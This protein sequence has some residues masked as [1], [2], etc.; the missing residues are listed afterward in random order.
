MDDWRSPKARIKHLVKSGLFRG[1]ARAGRFRPLSPSDNLTQPCETVPFFGHRVGTSAEMGPQ[2]ETRLAF[3]PPRPAYEEVP[4]LFYAP[5][6]MAWVGGCLVE[7]FSVQPIRLSDLR[8]RPPARAQTLPACAVVECDYL[9]SYG[10]WVHCYLG[11]LLSVGF[12]DVPVLIP[13]ALA[14]KSYV[15]RDLDRAGINWIAATGWYHIEKA[16]VL[17]K[18]N[19]KFYFSPQDVAAFRTAFA[20]TPTP[21]TPGSVSYLGRFDL[22]GETVTRQF[23]SDAA[24]AYVRSIGG[25]VI[26]QADLNTTTAADYGQEAETVIGDH[27]SGLLNIMFWAPSTVIELV[28]D[29]W[30]VNN[31]LFVAAGMGVRNF[32]VI[33]V[34]GLC[35]AEIGTRIEACQA[36]FAAQPP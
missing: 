8:A 18:P 35:A 25:R 14:Q 34:D 7:K 23:P 29:D 32:G 28:V 24:A 9:Y 2:K 1:F 16:F 36:H 22:T 20:V 15:R 3:C 13:Q 19:P 6:G 10:D 4:D 30:W 5:G 26:R 17:R 12:P 33:R 11:T 31:T 27:G 21:P